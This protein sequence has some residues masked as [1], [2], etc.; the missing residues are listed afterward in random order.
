VVSLAD[1]QERPAPP[2]LF[3]AGAELVTVDAVVLEHDGMPVMGL[4]A[5]DFA[6]SED[7][8][9]QEIAAFEAVHRSPQPAAVDPPPV[10]PP[11]RTSTNVGS[12]GE[13]RSFVIV[14]DEVHL[15]PAEAER[16]RSA[17]T[18]FLKTGVSSEDRVTLV[19]TAEGASWT[20]RI[21]EGREALLAAL[22]RLQGRRVG[23]RAEDAISDYEAVRIDRDRDPIVTDR[24]M[25]RF[26][27]SRVIVR[28]TRLRGD[29]PDRGENLETERSVVQTRAAQV[30]ARTAAQN[31]T[32][33]GLVERSISSLTAVRGRKTLVLVSGGL[34]QDS[35]LPAFR[36]VVSESRRANVAIY[37]LD[38]GGLEAAPS[39]LRAEFGAPVDFNDLGST[40]QEAR[41]RTEG[42][43]SLAV[44]TGGFSIRNTND[45]ADGFRRIG[46]ESAS[47]Y[48]LG[49]SPSNKK[50]DGR[51]RKIEVKVT[52]PGVKV[53]ARR[54][55]YAP[56]GERAGAPKST[57]PRDAALQR[58]LDS[59]FDLADV[60]LRA[61]S[62]VFSETEPGKANV[63]VTAEADIRK[64]TFD[65]KGGVA[66]DTL[67]YML[68][69][70]DQQTGEFHRFDHQF[71]MSLQPE[72]RAR[73][74]RTWFPIAR[75]LKLAPGTYQARIV[76][77]DRNSGRVGSLAHA[78]EVPRISGLRISTP[79]LSD[80]LHEATGDSR[81][82]EPTARR[83][84]APTGMLHCRFEVYGAAMDPSTGQANVTAGF[85]IRRSDGR[86]LTAAPPTRLAPG[87]D[88]SLTRALGLPLDGVPAGHYELIV[89]VTDVA[90][91]AA[92]EAREPF[93][94]EPAS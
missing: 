89:V 9:A 27:A 36:R 40:L 25:R 24:V 3:P 59:P 28:E 82:P 51:F 68:V 6:V 87:P 70:V 26:V 86:F 12:G 84:F 22:G 63:L 83:T 16:A 52:R 61:T 31:E 56:G 76:V 15:V 13:G 39:T 5:A 41:E 19:G 77:R 42:S 11:P 18:D 58:A 7:G 60:P 69:V 49:Y 94:I 37:F 88:G 92:A 2:P 75:E 80:R 10:V 67:E 20:A 74:A 35:H 44:D 73:Y 32:T 91:G 50:A 43:E 33:L 57:E 38:A 23:E 30:Y 71:A 47:Y 65:E 90:G 8:V 55:Y 72:T 78:F 4:T 29:S 64:L 53:R 21:A 17:L 14:F 46:R 79:L 54:G 34:A 62:H 85:S 66:K 1:P 81:T 93:V 48:L 45:L